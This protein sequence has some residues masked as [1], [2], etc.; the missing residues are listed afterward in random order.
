MGLSGLLR[1]IQRDFV[2][3]PPN[4]PPRSQPETAF[5]AERVPIARRRTV[6]AYVLALV[7]PIVSGLAMLPL[8]V[9]HAQIVA[10][11]LFVPVIAVAVLGT[12]GPALVAALAAG[13][14][15]D[16]VH[17]EPYWHIAIEDPDDIAT[18]V[19]LLIVAATVGLLCS[20]V[21][22]LRA[23]DAAR[24]NELQHLVL[25][26]RSANVATDVDAL[27]REV[28]QHLTAVLDVRDCRWHAGYHGTVGAVLLPTGVLTGDP[29]ALSTDR[30]Q[31]PDHVELPAII[32]SREL[33]RFVV[34]S[35]RHALISAEERLTA[36]TIV[37]LFAHAAGQLG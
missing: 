7:L 36:A 2:L 9:D 29:S 14:I 18:T 20:Q 28:C 11:V 24:H 25:F 8:R 17:T 26:A 31:L 1:R 13:L 16:V 30:A 33:G 12:T 5:P 27:A 4:R 35:N 37:S 32:G 22:Q 19:T 6:T 23:R 21:V 10:L 15:Y 3:G 34:T